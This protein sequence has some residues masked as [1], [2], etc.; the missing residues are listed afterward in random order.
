[1][2]AGIALTH[3]IWSGWV[4][5]KTTSILAFD[6]AQFFPSLNHCLLTLSLKKAGLNP[7]V[8][9]FFVDFLVRRKTNY[10]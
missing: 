4:K 8:T 2:D 9:S 7:K 5:N 10:M 1:M 3:V 6:I